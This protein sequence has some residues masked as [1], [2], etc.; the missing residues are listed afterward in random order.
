MKL[1]VIA[2]VSTLP[3]LNLGTCH[4]ILT[5]L[6]L[7]NN[8][9]AQ[10]YKQRKKEGDY[11]ILDND[12]HENGASSVLQQLINAAKIVEPDEIVLP[13]MIRNHVHTLH[14]TQKALPFLKSQFPEAKLMAVP[15][16]KTQIEWDHCLMQHLQYSQ[17]IDVIGIPRVYAD[18]FGSWVPAVESTLKFMIHENTEIHLLG[19]PYNLDSAAEVERT[20]PRTVRSTDTAK[21]LHYALAGLGFDAIEI[22]PSPIISVPQIGL[23]RDQRNPISRPKDFFDVVLTQS[24]LNLAKDNIS[25]MRL[26]IGDD[27]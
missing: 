6:V 8:T 11:I 18:D 1:G 27:Q 21:P 3:L 20:Y 23:N 26:S 10:F 7:S 4:L 15:Q 12:A 24:Q 17:Y 2:P 9:Y 16:G 22:A 5:S 14:M 19:S 13:D 25:K